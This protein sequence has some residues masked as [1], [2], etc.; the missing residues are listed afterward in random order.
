MS[1]AFPFVREDRHIGTFEQWLNSKEMSSES[2]HRS[3]PADRGVSQGRKFR[4]E[5]SEQHLSNLNALIPAQSERDQLR[6]QPVL[7]EVEAGSSFKRKRREIRLRQT[8]LFIC[9]TT[10]S[11]AA[12]ISVVA[13]AEIAK[14]SLLVDRQTPTLTSLQ[15]ADYLLSL[16]EQSLK[17]PA[18]IA[19]YAQSQLHMVFPSQ[20]QGQ[21]AGAAGSSLS[22]ANGS[23]YGLYY[24]PGGAPTTTVLQS[25]GSNTT[26]KAAKMA[27]PSTTLNVSLPS[28]A[29]P[30]LAGQ[31]TGSVLPSSASTTITTTPMA[32]S[33]PIANG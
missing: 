15:S 20:V 13:R 33:S 1:E 25:G 17:A 26:A 4:A 23:P 6:K 9:A 27:K 2:P 24:T 22:S 14:M 32:G 3:S 5:P 11:A 19:Q 8:I 28:R 18:R 21:P 16:R 7:K 31:G 30:A 29:V 10:I 12:I